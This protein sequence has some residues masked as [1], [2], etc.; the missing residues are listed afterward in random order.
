MVFTMTAFTEDCNRTLRIMGTKGEI[1][2]D[3]NKNYIEFI[4]FLEGRKEVFEIEKQSKGHGGGDFGI[5]HDFIGLLNDEMK[6][7]N[8]ITGSVHSHI[9]A[10]AADESRNTNKTINIDEFVKKNI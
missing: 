4:D 10:F 7:T 8:P 3:M 5:M 1:K 9:L 2:A 6:N